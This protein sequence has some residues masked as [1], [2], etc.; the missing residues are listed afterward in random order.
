MALPSLNSV[1][2]RLAI[3]AVATVPVV[4]SMFLAPRV[5]DFL[6]PAIAIA[7][8]LMAALFASRAIPVDQP[9]FAWFIVIAFVVAACMFGAFIGV[10]EHGCA[11]DPYGCP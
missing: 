1:A 6:V 7:W 5:A 2:V 10:W 9:R 3:V 11:T 8:S 4:F